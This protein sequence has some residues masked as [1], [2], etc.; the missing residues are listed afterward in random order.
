[1][2]PTSATMPPSPDLRP[3][4]LNLTP[5]QQQ[6]ILAATAEVICAT[7]LNRPPVISDS[8]LAGAARELVSGAFVSLKRGQNLR[9]CCGGLQNG[10]ITLG[11]ALYDAAVRSVVD[12]VRFPVVSPNELE[13]LHMEIWLLHSPESVQARGEARAQAVRTGGKHGLIVTRGGNRG[14]LLPGVA[15]DHDWDAHRFLQQTCIKAGLH[16]SMWQDDATSVSTFEGDVL[17]GRLGDLRADEADLPSVIPVG[18]NEVTAYVAFC[19]ENLR[20]LLSGALPSYYLIGQRDF[21]VTGVALHMGATGHDSGLQ[22]CHLAL[23]QGVP[24]Q[25]TLFQLTRQAAEHLAREGIAASRVDNLPIGLTLL[26]DPNLHGHMASVE[27][28]GLDVRRRGLA[29]LERDRV[30]LVFD[31]DRT[32]ESLLEEAAR[33]AQVRGAGNAGVFSFEVVTSEPTVRLSTA[34]RPMAGPAVRLPAVAG[35]FYPADAGALAAVVDELLAG[36]RAA[37][38]WAAALVPHAGLRYSGRLAAEVLSRV[39][40]PPRVIVLGPKHTPL[41]MEWAVAPH[42]TWRIPGCT[43]PS[44]PAFARVLADAIPGLELDAAAHQAEH[45]IEVQLPLLARLAPDVKVVGIAIGHA[46]LASCLR[47]A[48]GLANVL[49][50]CEEQPLL[51]ISSDMNHFATDEATRQLD[52]LALGVLE[53]LDPKEIHDTVS[54]NQISMCGILPAVIVLETLRRLGR[55]K[56]AQRVGYAT[57]ADVTHDTSRVVGYAGMLFG[58]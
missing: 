12:D 26:F 47:F 31:V 54:E 41:G 3:R 10:P 53:G 1:M 14:L 18:R 51:L 56:R 19:R 9:G 15:A 21:N 43:L 46:D 35:R 40:L 52:A 38:A 27:L 13:H 36:R 11:R 6:Y 49:R 57:S 37:E 55:L 8:T 50:R 58:T 24:L 4:R 22:F 7:A 5:T 32:A 39:R 34:P 25:A 23:R 28:A 20:A 48:E 44:D 33:L 29:A 16:P 2:T 42:E 30:G 17:R 45:A